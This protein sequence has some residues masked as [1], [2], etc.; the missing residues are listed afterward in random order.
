MGGF[1]AL[2]KYTNNQSQKSFHPR[3]RNHTQ[4]NADRN[5]AAETS[6]VEK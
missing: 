6:K 3:K 1:R 2:T 4:A 5:A